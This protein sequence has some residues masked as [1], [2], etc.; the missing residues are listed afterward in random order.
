MLTSR[1]YIDTPPPNLKSWSD[2]AYASDDPRW[3]EKSVPS[4]QPAHKPNF[5]QTHQSVN[6]KQDRCVGYCG[7]RQMAWQRLSTHVKYLQLSASFIAP[8]GRAYIIQW[9]STQRTRHKNTA[10]YNIYN[11]DSFPLAMNVSTK[12]FHILFFKHSSLGLHEAFDND[13]QP[14]PCF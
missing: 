8:E 13:L 14:T 2:H 11:E 4:C 10:E 3:R 5:A 6:E 7:K 12:C 1:D 9:E